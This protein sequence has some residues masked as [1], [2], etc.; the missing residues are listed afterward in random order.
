MAPSELMNELEKERTQGG[1]WEAESPMKEGF[2]SGSK[3]EA[4]KRGRD[5]FLSRY[6]QLAIPSILPS[7]RLARTLYK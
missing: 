4:S 2:A 6:F 7:P 5:Y 1:L 3:R